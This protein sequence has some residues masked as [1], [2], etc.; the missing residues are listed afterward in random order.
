M[1]AH[2]GWK[3][4]DGARQ[5]P[6]HCCLIQQ[7]VLQ[8]VIKEKPD[9]P[10]RFM[11]KLLGNRVF[12]LA[13]C[14][15]DCDGMKGAWCVH[16][17]ASVMALTRHCNPLWLR[18]FLASFLAQAVHEWLH[19]RRRCRV[20]DA[21]ARVGMSLHGACLPDGAISLQEAPKAVP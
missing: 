6:L 1:V 10:Y 14:Q 17:Q 5:A 11:A 8:A 21:G 9:D 12:K 15:N 20:C 16:S 18:L 7:A 13:A 19:R 3:P 2:G 4:P